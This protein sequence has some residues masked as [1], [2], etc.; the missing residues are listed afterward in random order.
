[1]ETYEFTLNRENDDGTDIICMTTESN[2][3]DDVVKRFADF[4]MACEFAPESIAASFR[5]WMIP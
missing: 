1:M 2:A 4:L 3:C 5:S